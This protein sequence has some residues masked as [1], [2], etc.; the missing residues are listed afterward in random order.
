MRTDHPSPDE[1]RDSL[2]RLRVE[3]ELLRS[4]QLIDFLDHVVERTLAGKGAELKAYTLAVD[5]FKRDTSFDPQTDSIV[6]VQAGRLRKA[7]DTVYRRGVPG[8]AVRINLPVGRYVP[9]FSWVERPNTD[10]DSSKRFKRDSIP[11]AAV[12]SRVARKGWSWPPS[13][14]TMVF[15][16]LILGAAALAFWFLQPDRPAVAV[17]ERPVIVVSHFKGADAYAMDYARQFTPMLVERLTAF[18]ELDIDLALSGHQ[19]AEARGDI[20]YRLGGEVSLSGMSIGIRATV[21]RE[22]APDV[23]WSHSFSRASI[24]ETPEQ[25]LQQL[26]NRVSAN[27]GAARG[28][29]Q[30]DARAHLPD[31]S[32]AGAEANAY[33]CGLLFRDALGAGRAAE[34]ETARRC[35]R[36]R[37]AADEGDLIARAALS[38]LDGFDARRTSAPGD[39]LG[40]LL[41]KE[42]A[43]AA[44]AVR[45]YPASSFA[46]EL[47]GRIL[48]A[49]GDTDGAVREFSSSLARNP[50]NSDAEASLGIML[51][52]RG[53]RQGQYVVERAIARTLWPAGWY[54]TVRA[55]NGLRR[56]DHAA[57]IRY[58]LTILRGDAELGLAIIVAAAPGAGRSDLLAA[59][60]PALLALPQFRAQGILPRLSVRIA[61]QEV[62][63][64]LR[65]GLIR[66]GLTPEQLD[67]P[68]AP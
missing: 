21:T 19:P 12:S 33:A 57:A 64:N 65:F 3:P 4:P 2:A 31:T 67:V 5:V 29:V 39:N 55:V 43:A 15:V 9:S 11:G 26:A 61:D 38:V 28:A 52:L 34:T 8:A 32:F 53:E 36:G 13:T 6:R 17:A 30:S 63:D 60:V 1:I 68:F 27:I 56:G 46:H 54:F 22:S 20:V 59:N 14:R 49:A 37:V 23:I 44:D 41:Q 48:L 25:T 51:A 24:G 42:V 16:A 66:A 50:G 10:P 40:D 58:A 45:A 62:L 7:L 35:Y 18:G 47:Y